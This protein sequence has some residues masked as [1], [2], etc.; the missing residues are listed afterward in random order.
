MRP[1]LPVRYNPREGQFLREVSRL[2]SVCKPLPGQV[3]RCFRRNATLRL[4]TTFNV[5]VQKAHSQNPG[6]FYTLQLVLGLARTVPPIPTMARLS[7]GGHSCRDF[8]QYGLLMASLTLC[9]LYGLNSQGTS[10]GV[11]PTPSPSIRARP[12]YILGLSARVCQTRT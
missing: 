3:A 11:I 12:C 10:A 8:S 9:F 7:I 5:M 4:T 2:W 6:S 1:H